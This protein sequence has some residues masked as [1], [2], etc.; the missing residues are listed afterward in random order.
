[1]SGLKIVVD[2]ANGAAYKVAPTVL[3]ELGAE[4][5]LDRRIAR[6]LQHQTA[7]AARLIPKRCRSTSSCTVPISAIALDGD[8]D[9]LAMVCEKGEV[10]DGDQLMAT[11][12]SA[13]G[14]TT[15]DGRRGGRHRHV[16][17]RPGTVI[18]AMGS[19]WVRTQV[20]DRYVHGAHAGGRLQFG[21]EQSGHIIMTDHATTATA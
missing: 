21:G 7:V 6:R 15:P 14:G 3:W 16:E 18:D 19:S 5:D 9:R 10:I 4:G 11:I 8:A 1:L 2:C 17:P 12:A 20:G 13:G